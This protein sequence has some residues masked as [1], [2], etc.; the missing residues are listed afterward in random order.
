MYVSSGFGV[1]FYAHVHA[2]GAV[3][4]SERR[5]L[6]AGSDAASRPITA[7]FCHVTGQDTA[8]FTLNAN[9]PEDTVLLRDEILDDTNVTRLISG[10]GYQ[11]QKSMSI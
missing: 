6:G 9:L 5:G 4:P 10:E 8:Q 3:P 11:L 2:S 1:H 7:F